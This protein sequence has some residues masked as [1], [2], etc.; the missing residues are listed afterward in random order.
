MGKNSC[1]KRVPDAESVFSALV[2]TAQAFRSL[3]GGRKIDDFFEFIR[4]SR[5]KAAVTTFLRDLGFVSGQ[6]FAVL[7]EGASMIGCSKRRGPI[8]TD[9]NS[10]SPC[11]STYWHV[12]EVCIGNE[13][14][15]G[16]L[17]K[18]LA[19][20]EGAVF[21]QNDGI[22]LNQKRI[23]TFPCEQ[24]QVCGEII[25]NYDGSIF[26]RPDWPHGTPDSKEGISS[27]WRGGYIYLPAS[28]EFIT[29]PIPLK[30][31]PYLKD[32]QI[33]WAGIDSLSGKIL[34]YWVN[35]ALYSQSFYSDKDELLSFNRSFSVEF[36]VC[37]EGLVTLTDMQVRIGCREVLGQTEIDSSLLMCRDGFIVRGL[38]SPLN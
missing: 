35:D 11:H 21:V 27:G 7:G 24:L 17:W 25:V 3:T 10:N 12:G 37:S 34:T 30:V 22:Y 20:P 4:D 6:R 23:V 32:V 28:G 26:Y 19:H 5:K 16:F 15:G 2:S 29:T 33:Q 1:K 14:M 38:N 31:T 13:D 8:L 9:E 36:G 18:C